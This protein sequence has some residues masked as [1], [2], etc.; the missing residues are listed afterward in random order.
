[1]PYDNPRQLPD[2]IRKNLPEHAQDIFVKAFNN[3]W[4]QYREP[5]DRHGDSTREETAHKVAWT[6]V[7]QVYEKDGD[8]WIRKDW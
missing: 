7:K 2:S 6:A 8:T 3:A 1:M 5:G 4:E